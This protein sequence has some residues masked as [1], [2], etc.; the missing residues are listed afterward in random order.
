MSVVPLQV[1][2]EEPLSFLSFAEQHR[3]SLNMLIRQVNP[4]PYTQTL[5]PQ[6][7]TLNPPP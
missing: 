3:A 2:A 4:Q 7:S 1:D 5:N 6:P